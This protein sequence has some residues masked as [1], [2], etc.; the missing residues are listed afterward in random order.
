MSVRDPARQSESI[1]IVGGGIIGLSLAWR[2][3]QL[4]WQVTV[5]DQSKTGT[6]ASWAAAGMLAPGGEYHEHSPALAFGLESRRLYRSFI[7]E[8]SKSSGTSID[9]AE[10]GA[11]ELAYTA[12]ELAALEARAETQQT[13]GIPSK[14]L[15]RSRV[16]AFWPRI[17]QQGLHGAR[18]YPEDAV[19]NPRELTAAL[20]TVCAGLGV[21]ISEGLRV[22]SVIVED[23]ASE[24]RTESGVFGFDAAVIAAGAWSSSIE[25]LG[26]PPIP[27]SKPIKGHLVGYH[28]P[29]QTCNTIV[30]HRN[31]Y[32]LQRANGLLVVG[33]SVEDVG[34]NRTVQSHIVEELCTSAAEIFPHLAETTP[35]EVWTGFRPGGTLHVG[36]WHSSRLW[37]AYGHYRNGILLAPWTARKLSD[38]INASRKT[39]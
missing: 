34:W 6:E 18:F 20:R 16:V 25:V 33:A 10:N 30:R 8:L 31:V 7:E 36:R 15:D 12:D 4:G 17:R 9:F 32:A 14:S 13:L 1:A 24:I 21:E 26:V 3:A 38:E 23:A 5:F 27:S 19:V 2:L 28:Q 11:L 29:D 39:R 37:L 35:L 22:T